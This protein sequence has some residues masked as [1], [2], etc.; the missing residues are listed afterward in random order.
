LLT[1]DL[2]ALSEMVRRWDDAYVSIHVEIYGGGCGRVN[3][4]DGR[5]GVL[6]V[7]EVVSGGVEFKE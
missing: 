2:G 3:R 1:D 6:A 7:G 5:G 4:W